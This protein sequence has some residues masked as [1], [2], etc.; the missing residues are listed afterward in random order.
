METE[1]AAP[2]TGT[3][4]VLVAEVIDID[5]FECDRCKRQ[6]TPVDF[7]YIGP[8]EEADT[9]CSP[10]MAWKNICFDCA[11]SAE[12]ERWYGSTRPC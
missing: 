2:R 8:V 5:D 7:A 12:M 11:T 4:G 9:Q 6:G 3:D 1:N 10:M